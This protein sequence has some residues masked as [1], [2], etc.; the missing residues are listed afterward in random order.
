MFFW[1]LHFLNIFSLSTRNII[2]FKNFYSVFTVL[3]TVIYG[4]SW[5]N[6]VFSDNYLYNFKITNVIAANIYQG[7]SWLF[8]SSIS[9]WSCF[10]LNWLPRHYWFYIFKHNILIWFVLYFKFINRFFKNTVLNKTQ[11]KKH[12]N[13][14]LFF[15][16]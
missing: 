15:N 14:L 13:K 6:T 10:V 4:N 2:K 7:L 1:F 12:F 16:L 9:Y 3:F 5:K 11:A 8:L